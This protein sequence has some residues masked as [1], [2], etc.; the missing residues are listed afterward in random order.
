M[1]SPQQRQSLI[2]ELDGLLGQSRLKSRIQGHRQQR[3]MLQRLRDLLALTEFDGTK[4]LSAEIAALTAQRDALKAEI[5]A[6][7]TQKAA[8]QTAHNSPDTDRAIENLSTLTHRHLRDLDSSVE[9]VFHT[10]QQHL[11]TYAIELEQ[12]I[13]RMHRLSGQSE[14]LVS[15][16]VNRLLHQ[17]PTTAL[18]IPAPQIPAA[19]NPEDCIGTLGELLSQL[20]QSGET[21]ATIGQPK[22]TQNRA[23]DNL[24]ATAFPEPSRID[25]NAITLA[26]IE[27]LFADLPAKE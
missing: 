16:L 19:V 14:V 27:T 7:N 13:D 25:M 17:V 22:I 9:L 12:G 21:P 20:T 5:V 1:L 4:G 24:T 26:D 3:Q 23:G 18:P 2:A 10:L 6:L 11:Q 8:Q 15:D